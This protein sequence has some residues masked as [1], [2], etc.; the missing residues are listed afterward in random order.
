M[1]SL[2]KKFLTRPIFRVAKRALPGL[3]ET[4]AAAIEAG[5]T[6]WEA[7]I[8]T[9]SPDWAQLE[10]VEAPRLS[11]VEQAFIDGPCRELCQMLDDW[12]INHTRV[13]LP[14]DVWDFLRA[15]RFFGMIIPEEYG[16]LGFSAFAHSEVIR[17]LST[18]SITAAVTVMVPNSLGP[19]ELLLQFGTKAQQDHW[20]PRLADGRDLPAFGLTSEEAG[21]DAAAMVDEGIV[22]RGTYEGE[23]TLG[24]R[25]N[26]SKRYIS[27]APVCTLLGLA[28]RL[29]D[30]DGLLG[31]ETDLGITCA[32]VPADLPGISRGHR[33]IPSGTMFQNGPI[34]GEDVFIP[35]DSI[36]GGAENTGRGWE[37]LMSAL[38]AGRG[39]S[40]PS[41]SAAATAL[42]AHSS[43]AYAR[44]RQQ[45][46]IPIGKFGGIQ[47]PLAR[48]AAAAYR[49][50]AARYLTCSGI[51][52]GHKPAVI[53][54]IMKATATDAMRE[55][56][57][58]AMDI[59][60]GKA[61]I[62]GPRNYLSAIHRAIPIGITVEG[63]NV[64]T[65]SLI[66]FG[67]GAIRAHPHLLDE[68]RALDE[69]DD[70]AAL[71][72][73]D[74]H[75]WAHAGHL[76]SNLLRAMTRAY[77]GGRFA[78]APH[79]GEATPI[80]GEVSR[81]SAA[82]A[83]TVEAAF[84]TLGGELKRRE[85][86]SGRLGDALSELYFLTA[87][88]KRWEDEGR[89][90]ADFPLVEYN[91]ERAFK[92]ISDSL[93]A[94]LSNLPGTVLPGL[95]RLLCRPASARRGPDDRL[96]ERCAELVYEDTS[97]RSRV[98]GR[99]FEGCNSDG[100]D[101]L[102]R[103]YALVNEVEPTRQRLRRTGQSA[104]E[105]LKAGVISEADRDR[106]AAADRAV[107]EVVRVDEFS[108]EEFR[109][110]FPDAAEHDIALKQ[111]AE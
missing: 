45:F 27:L 97:A 105:A 92:R 99:M 53:S 83:L 13:D 30:P 2:R 77:T 76:G 58:D 94:V 23:D 111:V 69:A 18:R 73:F 84:I 80:Y 36:I 32:L 102:N 81:W 29:Q 61:V 8:F 14:E 17:L 21:S 40:L 15:H 72:G 20:L 26:F 63:S 70:A 93:D 24:I 46:G 47:E 39:I 68:I 89:Q 78:P 60:A 12:E 42:G 57:S 86:I 7:E 16:G 110:L 87:V 59:H 98:L 104:E 41:L 50:D 6:W 19:G 9:G 71:D 109:R 56:I 37:M 96:I 10:E 22:C 91:A 74:T 66:I 33:H 48:L 49:L 82:F 106:L 43:G 79:A 4:E 107:R 55:A 95:V 100:I 52:A 5:D 90:K 54:A 38:A 62:D 108:L 88:L 3:S 64:V 44:V 25:L 101:L 1:K 85:M 31:G 28:F 35:L 34:S 11:E 67:Q 65:R 75:F 103:A 51:D